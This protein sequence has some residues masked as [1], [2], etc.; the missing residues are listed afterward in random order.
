MKIKALDFPIGAWNFDI[1]HVTEMGVE[2]ISIDEKTKKKIKIVVDEVIHFERID[3][4][5]SI[6]TFMDLTSDED[7]KTSFLQFHNRFFEILDERYAAW[8]EKESYF[9]LDREWFKQYAFIFTESF[10]EIISSSPPTYSFI[11]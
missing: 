5:Y 1:A 11:E 7:D 8:I 10:V 2:I 6:D 3:E 9:P 4:S